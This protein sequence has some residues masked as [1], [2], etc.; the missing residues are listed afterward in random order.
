MT[1][2]AQPELPQPE[3]PQAHDPQRRQEL[4]KQHKSYKDVGTYAFVIA[5]VL[6]LVISTREVPYLQ[7]SPGPV[8][9]TI[10]EVD[11]V[12]MVE[13]SGAKTYPTAGELNLMTVRERGGPF[14]ELS[15]PEAFFGWINPI[16]DVVPS[17]I[18]YPEGTTGQEAQER[19]AIQFDTSQAA[20]S[21]AA[22]K[23]LGYKVTETV[24]VAN[25]LDDS[26]AGGILKDGDVLVRVA[27]T[28]VTSPQ[29]TVKLV[30]A[31]KP[32]TTIEIDIVRDGKPMTV[33]PKLVASPV[34]PKKGYLGIQ[35]MDHYE[36]P[37][38]VEFGVEGVGGPSAGM[39]FAL[40]IIDK[41]V[42]EQLNNGKV[43]SGTGTI[44]SDGEVGP[45]GGVKQKLDAARTKGSEI[46]LVAKANCEDVIGNEPE[47]M[48]VVPVETLSEALDVLSKW[49]SGDK[50][51]PRCEATSESS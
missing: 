50:N 28:K 43:V 13:V 51:L 2:T 1:D 10:G 6:L 15:L 44:N 42:P 41:L 49:R 31:Q 29:Q 34:D 12:K 38:D 7:T 25:V 21:A 3:I 30:Q 32:G 19:N 16:D 26:P 35:S 39:M 22:M 45:V 9:N 48:P 17:D 27:G 20:A 11:G 23:Q 24:A 47:S 40:A 5:V 33:K 36:G 8:F 4:L 46:F 18:F 14:G 37:V